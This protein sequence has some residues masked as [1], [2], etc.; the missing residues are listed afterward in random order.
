MNDLPRIKTLEEIGDWNSINIPNKFSDSLTL[1]LDDTHSDFNQNTIN[2]IV[3]WKVNRYAK[4]KSE[5]ISLLNK[6]D[7]NSKTIDIGFT[8]EIINLLIN[9]KGIRLPMAST[10]LRFKNPNIYQIIDQ[11]VYRLLY[12]NELKI[13]D[14]TEVDTETYLSYLEKL[15]ESCLKYHI[16]FSK[17]DRILYEIDQIENKS[18]KL[19]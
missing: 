19:K 3:L 18:I 4:L 6:V 11:R 12:G 7:N 9:E 16:P 1:K 13:T 15:K 8:K 10:I 5:T 17:S 2:E 14:K